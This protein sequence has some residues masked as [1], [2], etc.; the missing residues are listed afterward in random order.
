MALVKR[1]VVWHSHFFVNGRRYRQSLHT[2]D[3]RRAQA[4]E[5]ELIAQAARGE[6]AFG[7]RSLGNLT[8]VEAAERYL[9]SR[10]LELSDATF[11]KEKQLTVHPC[12][13]FRAERLRN[14][15]GDQLLR[16][17]EFR[18]S[19]NAGPAI[20]NMEVGVIRRILKKARLWNVVGADI[21]P[22]REHRKIGR[23][24]TADQKLR[25]LQRAKAR[26]EWQ[27]VRLAAILALNTTMRGCEIKHLRWGDVDLM[28]RTL[29]ISKSKTEAGERIIPLNANAY[30]AILELR[31]RA[32]LTGGLELEHYLFPA[33]EHARVDPT[34]PLRSWRTAWRQLTRAIEC[35]SCGLLQ[36]PAKTCRSLG[37]QQDITG[38]KSPL[39]GLRFHDLRH[40]AITELAESQ[41]SEQTIMGI[42]GHV[43]PKMLAHYS[44]VRLA[45]KRRALDALAVEPDANVQSDTSVRCYDTKNDTKNE[46]G[47]LLW[48]EVVEEN[49]RHEETRTPDLYRVKV[50][51]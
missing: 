27:S 24:L 31:D 32:K 38:L 42:A 11:K 9:S 19:A 2:T 34:K 33:C 10:R 47:N 6:I 35:P 15:S 1:G 29:A 25:L 48:M 51:L 3:W 26:P 43:S 17:R 36:G 8:F 23:A 39:A 20:I 41:A 30:S 13:F 14:I 28:N 45:A 12:R 18:A 49:G 40:H 21:R 22:L 7:G 46:E 50:A 4:L 37:C 44:H 16:Y 5:K